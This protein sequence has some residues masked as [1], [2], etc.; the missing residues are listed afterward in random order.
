MNIRQLTYFCETVDC[1]SAAQAAERLYVAPTAISMQLSQLEETVGGALFDRSHRPMQLTA[2]GRFFYP[3]AKELLSQAL[4]LHEE[5]QGMASGHR[6]WLGIGFVRSTLFAILPRAV[7]AFRERY[8]EVQIDLIE[9]LSEYQPAQ[10]R[11]GRIHVGLSRFIGAF[12]RP[13]DLCY[14]HMLDDPFVA[15]LPINHPLASKERLTPRDFDQQDLIRYPKDVRSNFGQQM[16]QILSNAGVRTPKTYEAIE[17][18]TALALVGAGLGIT[19]VGRSIA[20]NNRSDVVF[21]PL[22]DLHD[23]TTL[24]AITRQ[25]EHNP[26]VNA[27]LDILLNEGVRC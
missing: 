3:R 24:V 1:G 8:P 23:D 17:I 18:H 12:E 11:S 27:F 7:R 2:L 26:T 20:Q 5:T 14:T 15:A 6:G 13:T 10:L 22:D 19:L 4:R 21:R 16:Q 9:M 25:E